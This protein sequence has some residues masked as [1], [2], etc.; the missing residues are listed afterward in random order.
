VDKAGRASSLMKELA[1]YRSPI[2]KY[3]KIVAS[4]RSWAGVDAAWE[5]IQQAARRKGHAELNPQEFIEQVLLATWP[6]ERLIEHD[7]TGKIAFEN[8][9]QEIIEAVKLSELPLELLRHLEPFGN[10]AATAS[11]FAGALGDCADRL[12]V[13]AKSHYDFDPPAGYRQKG[14]RNRKAF[15]HWMGAYFFSRCGERRDEE[16]AL[17]ADIVFRRKKKTSVDEVRLS[18]RPSTRAGRKKKA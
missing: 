18:R 12:H 13:L 6:V 1:R 3:Q 4:W 8:C 9:K 11:P 2:S 14:S 17:L 7:R 15:Y 16:V 10:R 5:K